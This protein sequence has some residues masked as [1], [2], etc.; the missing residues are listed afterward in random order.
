MNNLFHKRQLAA[1]RRQFAQTS[2]L[3]L[4]V[5]CGTQYK[6]G[7]VNIDNNSDNNIDQ[8]D[9]NWDLSKGLPF[10]DNSVDYIYHE[11]FIEHL[12]YEQ[13]LVFMQECYRVLKLGGVMRTACPDLDALIDDYRHDT[14]R[15]REWVKKYQYEWMP[16]R[17]YM[18]NISMNQAPWGHQ[19]VYNR[20]DLI[21]RLQQAG[22]AENGITERQYLESEHQHLQG[23]DN[24]DDSMIIESSK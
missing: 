10:D 22:F 15:E 18:L 24:R 8:L 4:H 2:P 19:Y 12:T 16:S 6:A 5:G 7:W 3:K 13:G 1:I 9:I 21:A 23:I 17:C 14:W 20:D 11:H